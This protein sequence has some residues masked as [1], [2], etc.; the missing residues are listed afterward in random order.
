M[1]KKGLLPYRIVISNE[2]ELCSNFLPTF[3]CQM[4]RGSLGPVGRIEVEIR[5]LLIDHQVELQS[6]S[7]AAIACLPPGVISKDNAAA[8]STIPQEEIQRRRDLGRVVL[9]LVSILQVV[10]MLTIR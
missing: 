7:T 4:L 2:N 5:T 1:F 3:S 6:F 10:K 8:T 9:F